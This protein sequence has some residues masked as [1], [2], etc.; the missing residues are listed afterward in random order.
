MNRRNAIRGINVGYLVE[1]E[2][3]FRQDPD[4]VDS[5]SRELLKRLGEPSRVPR[6]LAGSADDVTCTVTLA[7]AIRRYGHLA[8]RLDPL[9]LGPPGDPAL[10]LETYSLTERNLERLPASLVGG[11]VARRSKNAREAIAALREVY[12]TSRG[13]DWAHIHAPEERRWL[14]AMV[15]SAHYRPPNDRIDFLALLRRLTEV[16]AFE[17]YLHRTFP[18]K[19]RFSLEGLDILVPVLDEVIGEAAE[20]G[21]RSILIGMAHRGRLNVLAHVLGKPYSQILAE[22]KDPLLGRTFRDELGWTGDVKYH[23]GARRAIKGGEAVSLLISMPPNPSHVEAVDPVVEGMARAAGTDV[24]KSGPPRFAH[25]T[26]LPILVHGD[27]AFPGQGVV[28]ETLN[29]SRLPGYRTGGTIH[30]IANNQLGYT[31][32]KE[33]AYSTLYAS[34]LAKGFEIPVIHV[35]ADDPISCIEAARLAHGY[36]SR[37]HKDVLI[38]LVG[39]RRYGH[40]ESDEPSFT[41]PL[42]YQEIADHP[43]VRAQWAKEL[44]RQGLL[45]EEK[46][47]ELF[48]ERLELLRKET[49]ELQ[50]ERDLIEIHAKA[51][52]PGSARRAETG[53]ALHRLRR[54]NARLL[55]LP[56]HFRLHRKLEKARERRGNVLRDDAA[57]TVDWATAEE[58]ALASILEDGIAIRFTGEDVERGTFSQRHAVFHDIESGAM[59]IPLQ[60]LTGARAAFEI[61]NSPLTENATLAFEFGYNVQAPERLVI[62]EAQ[63]GDFVN[64]AQVVIDEFISSA[65]AKWGQTP[66]LVLLLPHGYEGHGPDHSSAYIERFLQLAAEINLRITNCTTAAQYFHL[67]RL[68]ASLLTE[69]P[70]PLI[71]FTP[72][73]LL[74]HEVSASS[75]RELSAGRF[76]RVIDDERYAGDSAAAERVRRLLCCSGKIYA[77]LVTSEEYHQRETIAICRVEQLYPFPQDDLMEVLSR[78]PKLQE[79][80]WVQEEPENMGAWEYIRARLSESSLEWSL[81]YVGRVRN[82][83]P[84]EG[85]AAW[86][87]VNQRAIIKK[88][89]APKADVDELVAMKEV[90]TRSEHHGNGN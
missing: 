27:A 19:F 1:L 30:I 60:H 12:S 10:E 88:A 75:P 24:H 57:R 37:F 46:S 16:E 25:D 6:E 47:Q 11:P 22:F 65:R 14:T 3:R 35:N 21:V 74:R 63:Y 42:R 33:D 68:Q 34:D 41:Q 86:H 13:F 31:T 52:P 62:W 9:G 76:Q 49:D 20:N 84:A 56:N 77:D 38:D 5:V 2:E 53:V 85:S 40:N 72:K 64:G 55:E 81:R 18:G 17:Q 32:E 78:Y 45:D 90:P 48:D 69:D 71:V 43:T 58:L 73:A 28:A 54:L 82:S 36:L 29:L 59:H 61:H 7:D 67:L 80:C 70:L 4:S 87:K 23:Q 51:P 79:L 83:S 89:F 15:E 8:A 44:H 66:S 50:P 39:Y 26:T